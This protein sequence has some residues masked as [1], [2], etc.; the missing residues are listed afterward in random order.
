MPSPDCCDR[1]SALSRPDLHDISFGNTNAL[2]LTFDPTVMAQDG[3]A[4]PTCP[5]IVQKFKQGSAELAQGAGRA[6]SNQTCITG[7]PFM[8]S[9]SQKTLLRAF[10]A[11]APC[12]QGQY[13][14][15]PCHE[16]DVSDDGDSSRL[17]TDR[18]ETHATLV[19][20]EPLR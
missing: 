14:R 20:D 1:N 11:S 12:H 7:S 19:A 16:G 2:G 15:L 17:A 6:R 3:W 9:S 4:R 13:R 10:E 5:S 18:Q 8:A